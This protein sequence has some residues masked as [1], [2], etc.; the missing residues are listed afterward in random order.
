MCAVQSFHSTS[1][2]VFFPLWLAGSSSGKPSAEAAVVNVCLIKAL[3]YSPFL[4][5]PDLFFTSPN[6]SI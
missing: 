3:S 5:L 4:K 6:T 1:L 2:W